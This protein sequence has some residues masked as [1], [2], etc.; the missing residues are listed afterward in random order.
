[1]CGIRLDCALKKAYWQVL[2]YPLPHIVAHLDTEMSDETKIRLPSHIRPESYTLHLDVDMNDLVYK[3]R[4]R[5]VIEIGEKNPADRNLIDYSAYEVCLHSVGMKVLGVESFTQG[6]EVSSFELDPKNQ[7]LRILFARPIAEFTGKKIEVEIE[8]A[9]LILSNSF[10]RG[11]YRSS[12]DSE[13]KESIGVTQFEACD[14]RRAL[15]CFDE[16]QFKAVFNVSISTNEGLV[17]LCNTPVAKKET[18]EVTKTFYRKAAKPEKPDEAKAAEEEDEDDE[19]DIDPST[20]E[21]FTSSVSRWTTHHFEPSPRMS[22]YL[23]A[24]AVGALESGETI[25]EDTGLGAQVDV[26]VWT[27]RGK[28]HLTDYA[29]HVAIQSIKFFTEKFQIPYPLKK[30]DLLAV[31]DFEAGAMENFGLVTYRETCILVDPNTTTADDQL[32]TALIVAHEVSHQWFGNLVTMQWWNGLWLNEGFATWCEYNCIQHLFPKL[33]FIERYQADSMEQAFAADASRFSHPVEIYAQTNAQIDSA[34]DAISYQKGCAVIRMIAEFMGED[35]FYSGVGKYLKKFAWQN[36]TTE[37]LWES[38][39]EAYE[40]KFGKPKVVSSMM[41]TW[42]NVMGYP[43]VS[44]RLAQGA[45]G[46]ELHCEQT[47]YLLPGTTNEVD[48]AGTKWNIPL[49]LEAATDTQRFQQNVIVPNEAQAV[50]PLSSEFAAAIGPS[51]VVL[52]NPVQSGLF[53]VD[54]DEELRKRILEN[55]KSGNYCELLKIPQYRS[56]LISNTTL[57]VAVGKCSSA[58]LFELL[59]EIAKNETDYYVWRAIWVSLNS[60]LTVFADEKELTT[61]MSTAFTTHVANL[62]RR[63]GLAKSLDSFWGAPTEDDAKEP[64]DAEL[65][66][67][68]TLMR[69]LVIRMTVGVVKGFTNVEEATKAGADALF[70]YQLME[71]GIKRGITYLEDPSSSQASARIIPDAREPIFSQ[72]AARGQTDKLRLGLEWAK[73]NGSADLSEQLA[74]TMSRMTSLET[75]DAWIAELVS[76]ITATA[77]RPL[78]RAQDADGAI[79]SFCRSPMPSH[80]RAWSAV[81]RHWKSLYPAIRGTSKCRR[82]LRVLANF[83]TEED[84]KDIEAFFAEVGMP[85]GAGHVVQGHVEVIRAKAAWHDRDV[86]ELTAKL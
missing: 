22:T 52:A 79:G 2:L 7:L 11:F 25:R 69:G 72:I 74:I 62:V 66:V 45:A 10:M 56:S 59:N 71:E 24:Y 82:V 32:G 9:G 84:A 75:V 67:L 80:R 70:L 13:G 43:V 57:A 35:L 85:E 50:V 44:V 51:T 38:L 61:K 68:E 3:G 73:N 1:M 31:P 14:A 20:F 41:H 29:R 23:L 4:N 33:R 21:S 55:L 28:K 26:T 30:M 83:I 64:H 76:S 81:K 46:L 6:L 49:T 27:T 53:V 40:A 5:V 60:L 77:E 78:V 8:F 16:P 18:G 37:D 36:A 86:Q 48:S 17:V 54:Y 65:A 42:I 63:K 19:E 12:A 34:F 47:Q 15:P 58:Y 39:D